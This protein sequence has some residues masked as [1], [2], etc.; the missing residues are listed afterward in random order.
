MSTIV[1]LPRRRPESNEMDLMDLKTTETAGLRKSI[2][3]FRERCVPLLGNNGRKKTEFMVAF[4]AAVKDKVH[5][6]RH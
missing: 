5:M 2:R 1:L 3:K 6:G 4:R